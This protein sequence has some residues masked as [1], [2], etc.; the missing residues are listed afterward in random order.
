[1]QA[2]M[3]KVASARTWVV[4]V[5]CDVRPGFEVAAYVFVR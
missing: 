4:S 5:S 3:L 1:M 2:A